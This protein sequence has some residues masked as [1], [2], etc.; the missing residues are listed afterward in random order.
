MKI[1]IDD[2]F[3]VLLP[4]LF[5]ALGSTAEGL[6]T[7]ADTTRV[8]EGW[9][10]EDVDTRVGSFPVLPLTE[11]SLRLPV[12]R[13][14]YHLTPVP[15]FPPHVYPFAQFTGYDELQL[16]SLECTGIFYTKKHLT[17]IEFYISTRY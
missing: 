12:Y 9:R 6:F 5:A 1:L 14:P 13:G 17:R 2:L 16:N 3:V 15:P 8:V 10:T 4:P 11:I 7:L